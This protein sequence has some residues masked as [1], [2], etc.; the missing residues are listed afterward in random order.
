[1]DILLGL[2]KL[3]PSLMTPVLFRGSTN[4]SERYLE[5]SPGLVDLGSQSAIY[6]IVKKALCMLAWSPGIVPLVGYC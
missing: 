3:Q 5:E 1:M 2:G 6:L 4:Q